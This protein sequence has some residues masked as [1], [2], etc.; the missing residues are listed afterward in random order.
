MKKGKTALPRHNRGSATLS[1]SA[2]SAPSATGAHFI[3]RA[4]IV[5]ALRGAGLRQML[6]GAPG[7]ATLEI[8]D[9]A[10]AK[11]VEWASCNL[12]RE[13]SRSGNSTDWNVINFVSQNSRLSANISVDLLQEEGSDELRTLFIVDKSIRFS[14]ISSAMLDGSAVMGRP[15]WLIVRAAF[16]VILGQAPPAALEAEALVNI[17]LT[18][19]GSAIRPK[20]GSVRAIA[21]LRGLEN[22]SFSAPMGMVSQ[23]RSGPTLAELSGL[24]EA[25]EWGSSL[26]EDLNL[27]RQGRIHWRDVDRGVLLSG[28]F[29]CGKTTF[30]QAL[31]RTCGVAVQVHSLAIWQSLGNLNDVL[32]AMRDAFASARSSAPC[33]L[34]ID[35]IDSFGDRRSFKGPNANYSRQVVNALLEMLDGFDGREGIVV[36]GAT[37][38]PEA[39][40][41]ALKRPGRLDRHIQIPL[42]DNDARIGIMRYHL[43]IDLSDQDLNPISKRLAGASGA[44]LEQIIRDGRRVAR[45]AGRSIQ[46]SD[47]EASLPATLK[48]SD[49]A[50]KRSCVHEAGHL[51]VALLLGDEAGVSPVDSVVQREI[52]G[53]VAGHTNCM[54]D[55]GFDRTRSSCLAEATVLLAGI[56][57][58]QVALGAIGVTRGPESSSDVMMTTRLLAELELSH[59]LGRSLVVVVPSITDQLFDRIA[60]DV[61]LRSEIDSLMH[62][63]LDRAILILEN[64]RKVFDTVSQVL[65]ENGIVS[66]GEVRSLIATYDCGLDDT[67]VKLVH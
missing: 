35:E 31:G 13:T 33:I 46:L 20:A 60:T 6:K 54:R 26:A 8:Y 12:L 10:D 44:V 24:G 56:A 51:I 52:V 45:R 15:D 18:A 2:Y 11:I 7:V 17:P 47:F 19:Y 43:G 16:I 57:G 38:Y 66:S 25:G 39:I 41:P 64:N 55:R 37:N 4:L 22:A 63:C 14:H 3:C 5:R 9:P 1:G 59:G 42:P 48:L 34:F 28:P 30:A 27:Y 53:T 29:G 65:L 61:M 32:A 36:V 50:Y 23:C 49:A 40:D 58:E 67:G 21:R 62:T